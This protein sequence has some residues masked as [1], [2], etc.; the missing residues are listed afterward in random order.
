MSAMRE[1]IIA[2]YGEHHLRRSAIRQADS[3]IF[4]SLLKG[5]GYRTIL[6]I[7]TFRGCT[8]AELSLYCERVVTI[9]LLDG[10]VERDGAGFD[11][12][13]FWSGIGAENIELV[14]VQN[15][16]EKAAAVS[17][18]DF[19]FA[20][21]D[22]AHDQASVRFDFELTKKCGRVLF[23]DYNESGPK[24]HVRQVVAGIPDGRVEVFGLFALWADR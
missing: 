2:K 10:E 4:E 7:G 16:A 24:Q 17:A 18:L 3:A 21:I 13:A 12:E 9:D 20:F 8:S 1:A 23:H 22:G 11:R 15:D 6:E 14:R 5:A 19:D